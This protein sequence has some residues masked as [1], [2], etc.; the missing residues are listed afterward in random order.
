MSRVLAD[1]WTQLPTPGKVVVLF[2]VS[3]V[4]VKWV[5]DDFRHSQV[6]ARTWILAVASV[7]GFVLAAAVVLK[8]SN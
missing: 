2:L 3:G 4:F 5:V 7:L 6:S 1:F 8:P